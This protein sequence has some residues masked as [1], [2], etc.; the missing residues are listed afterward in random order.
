MPACPISLRNGDPLGTADAVRACDSH[1]ESFLSRPSPHWWLWTLTVFLAVGPAAMG[2][3]QTADANQPGPASAVATDDSSVQEA[4]E[5]SRADSESVE[6]SS[7]VGMLLRPVF[8]VFQLVNDRAQSVAESADKLSDEGRELAELVPDLPQL[9]TTNNPGTGEQATE[10]G[11]PPAAPQAPETEALSN[12]LTIVIDRSAPVASQLRAIRSVRLLVIAL[13]VIAMVG[14]IRVLLHFNQLTHGSY[15]G[16]L[17]LL[18]WIGTFV[19]LAASL[20]LS[21]NDSFWPVPT[22]RQ[23]VAGESGSDSGTDSPAH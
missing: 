13:G 1:S 3:A 4:A 20:A 19:L 9:P 6:P 8:S 2:R 21:L 22:D 12:P 11:V 15:T 5:D 18:G 10:N 16:R 17:Q 14:L 7:A 23:T